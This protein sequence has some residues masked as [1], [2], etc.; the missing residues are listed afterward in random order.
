[1]PDPTLAHRAAGI[2]RSAHAG[3]VDKQGRDYFDFHLR[4]IAA[5]L[6]PFGPEAAAAGYLHDVLEDTDLTI[7]D[8]AAAG[9][10]SP[11]V[12]G[13][14]E[15][16]SKRPGEPYEELI[17]RAG[18]HPLGRLVKL[19]DNWHNLSSLDALAGSDPAT[20]ARLRDKYGTARARLTAALASAP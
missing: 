14:V 19:A 1:M 7:A 3:Q 4:P 13:A 20:A 12:L 16:V 6:E 9:V 11:L 18:R 8:L 15:S 10:T 17:E 5:L 2:A